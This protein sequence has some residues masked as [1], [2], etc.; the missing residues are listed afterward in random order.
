MKASIVYRIASVLLLLFAAGHTLGFRESDPK[1]GVDA[2]LAQ[3]GQFTLTCRVQPDLLGLFVAAGFSVGVFYLF[4]RYWHGSWA[5]F[6]QTLCAYAR[7]YVGR[8]PFA[9]PLSRL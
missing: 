7:Y 1:W 5:A 3:C 2:L 8:L 4:A 6:R 9:L